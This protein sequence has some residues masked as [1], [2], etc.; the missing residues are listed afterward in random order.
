MLVK[1]LRTLSTRGLV[2]LAAV[3][4]LLAV[5][6]T[7]I[8][9]ATGGSGPVPTNKPLPSAVHEGLAASVACHGPDPF[10]NGLFVERSLWSVR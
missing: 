8:A 7:A 4:A 2:A 10:T 5:G 6:G 1:Y 9:M 3:V